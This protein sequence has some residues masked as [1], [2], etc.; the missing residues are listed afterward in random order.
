MFNKSF[1]NQNSNV[2]D[3]NDNNYISGTKMIIN[4]NLSGAITILNPRI[5]FTQEMTLIIKKSKLQWGKRK[6]KIHAFKLR[7][8]RLNSKSLR[9]EERKKKK[10][11]PRSK[12]IK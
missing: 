2:R 7:S 5:Q 6:I 4:Q 11:I 12:E 1:W 10:K 8:L 9:V 3:E